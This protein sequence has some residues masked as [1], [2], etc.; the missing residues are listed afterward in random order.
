MRISVT[1]VSVAA[2]R[3]TASSASS[4]PGSRICWAQPRAHHV[5]ANRL[6]DAVTLIVGEAAS[7]I[8]D[9]SAGLEVRSFLASGAI[10][11]T[12]RGFGPRL[13]T[14]C[15]RLM[16]HVMAQHRVPCELRIVHKRAACSPPPADATC[17]VILPHRGPDA[18]LRASVDSLLRQTSPARIQ[19]AIDQAEACTGF[20]A[21][22]ADQP[23]VAAYRLAPCP[24]GPYVARHVLAL[25]SRA[26]AIAF[27]DADDMSVP[28]RLATLAEAAARSGAGIVGSH[29][30]QV[31]EPHRK[32]YAIR[33]PLDVNASLRRAGARHQLLFPTSLVKRE[34]IERV[35]GFSTFRAFSL[36]VAF[37]LSASLTTRIV[38]VDEFLY[39]RRRHPTSLT[40]R[41]DIGTGSDVRRA[42]VG[43]R[44]A[45]FAAILAGRLRLEDSSLAVRHREGPVAFTDLKT[46]AVTTWP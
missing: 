20:L 3:P 41:A 28:H 6:V 16:E 35:G 15:Y 24:V 10:A 18:Y 39:V 38:N 5:R 8:D 19:V 23:R 37:W 34:V 17:D 33:Y 40:M 11:A 13:E 36:D 22:I 12:L 32:V 2:A 4:I 9:R 21:D 26:A 30:L 14:W 45:D 31:H 42:I 43:R 25:R 46:G 27:Q 29:E 7:P 1:R 44:N